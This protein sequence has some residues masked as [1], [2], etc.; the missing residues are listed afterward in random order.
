MT[1]YRAGCVGS[2]LAPREVPPKDHGLT[3]RPCHP[4][5]DTCW[6]ADPKKKQGIAAMGAAMPWCDSSLAPMNYFGA[7]R[8]I[9]AFSGKETSPGLPAMR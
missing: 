5:R 8:R 9:V 1:D 2:H 7:G 6:F 3:S 4:E